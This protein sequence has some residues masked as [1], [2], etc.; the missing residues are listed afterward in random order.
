MPKR[1]YSYT[2][3]VTNSPQKGTPSIS[4]RVLVFL[5]VGAFTSSPESKYKP[6]TAGRSGHPLAPQQQQQQRQQPTIESNRAQQWR[7]LRRRRLG[8][9]TRNVD[10]PA[11]LGGQ[12]SASQGGSHRGVKRQGDAKGLGG[13]MKY[14]TLQ[15]FYFYIFCSL[16][17]C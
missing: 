5:G 6:C 9:L 10:A 12:L 3:Q 15:F 16:N 17:A 11:R 4:L 8:Q 7:R 2:R 1:D 13:D 14:T